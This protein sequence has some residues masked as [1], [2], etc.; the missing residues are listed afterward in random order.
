LYFPGKPSLQIAG[1]FTEENAKLVFL[2]S[3]YSLEGILL[4]QDTLLFIT[5]AVPWDRDSTQSE[6]DWVLNSSKSFFE[7]RTG[8][9]DNE[10]VVWLH[11]PRTGDYFIL[12]FSPFPSIR[13]P[14]V[15][16]TN[17]KWDLLVPDQWSSENLL[18]WKGDR[19]FT[20]YYH[21]SGKQVLLTAL[22]QMDCYKVEAEGRSEF[23]NTQLISYFNKQYGFVRLDYTNINQTSMRL[24]LIE[25]KFESPFLIKAT[26]GRKE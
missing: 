15:I 5:S 22:G 3:M 8:L 26:G 20:S 18:N 14:F 9:I 16:G 19:I 7:N 12:E 23:G 13:Y 21:I 6:C 2:T 11:P 1:T 25:E 10:S 24:E 4:Q 17:W